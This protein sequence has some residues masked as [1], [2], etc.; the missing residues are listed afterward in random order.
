MDN[1]LNN[2][3]VYSEQAP[4]IQ[5]RITSN[6]DRAVLTVTDRGVGIPKEMHE[7]IFER[8]VRV[9]RPSLG[10]PPGTG[11]GLFIGR[12]LAEQMGGS[13]RLAESEPGRGSTFV[14][15][16]PLAAAEPGAPVSGT[17]TPQPLGS[18]GESR[19]N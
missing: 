15:S 3:L 13:L 19:S 1:L 14:L 7:R 12:T 9:D 17:A 4:W 5:V 11:L 16:L 10:F 6:G 18:I 2:A 8:L